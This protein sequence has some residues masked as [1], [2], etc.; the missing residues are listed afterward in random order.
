MT[1]LFAPAIPVYINA[2]FTRRY[3]HPCIYQCTMH[4]T[5]HTSLYTSM[6]HS[7]DAT[8]IH[9]YIHMYT[10]HGL[11]YN[12]GTYTTKK[13]SRL[14]VSRVICLVLRSISTNLAT[15]PPHTP[16][17]CNV[18]H[19]SCL[20]GA[21]FDDLNQPNLQGRVLTWL[22]GTQRSGTHTASGLQ[23]TPP[24]SSPTPL[25]PPK[26]LLFFSETCIAV[27]FFPPG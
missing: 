19:T 10:T 6:H 4:T 13:L 12:Y 3:T 15:Q 5:L 26:K 24:P 1:R 22:H 16:P 27:D 17:P 21:V 7:H 11:Q 2:P 18:P 14:R 23:N 25:F 8:H 20:L 9:R